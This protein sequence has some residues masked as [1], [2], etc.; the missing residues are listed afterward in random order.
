MTQVAKFAKIDTHQPGSGDK[1]NV[2]ALR[3]ENF[4]QKVFPKSLLTTAI[5]LGGFGVTNQRHSEVNEK[6]PPY[7]TLTVFLTANCQW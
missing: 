5:T 6:R 2:L 4:P 3:H 7:S 1:H